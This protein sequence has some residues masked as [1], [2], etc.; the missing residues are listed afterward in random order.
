M[1]NRVLEVR[2]LTGDHAGEWNWFP[3]L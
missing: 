3:Q 2:L 1:H